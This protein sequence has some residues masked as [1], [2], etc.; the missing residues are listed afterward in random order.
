LTYF[1]AG[2]EGL[3]LNI[4]PRQWILYSLMVLCAAILISLHTLST[5]PFIRGTNRF[6][7]KLDPIM[8]SVTFMSLCGF[9]AM[10]LWKPGTASHIFISSTGYWLAMIYLVLFCTVVANIGWFWVI[11]HMDVGR[12]SISIFLIP[13]FALLYSWLLLDEPMHWPTF[14]GAAGIIMGVGIAGFEGIY[15]KLRRKIA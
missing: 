8:L 14:V 1:G 7:I 10:I 15:G 13:L 6:N 4:E 2:E 9:L 11:K 3:K 12:S 5:K